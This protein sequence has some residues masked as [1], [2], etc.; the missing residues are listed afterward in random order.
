MNESEDFYK[1]GLRFHCTRCSM[2]CRFDTGYVFLSENDLHRIA[3]G[4]GQSIESVA[5]N[6]CR[7]VDLGVASRLS[8]REQPNKDCVFWVHG[9]CSIYEHRPLQ[10]RSFPFWP[11][12]LQNRADWDEVERE[13]PG[14]NIG[15]V[16]SAEEIRGWLLAH[17]RDSL[18]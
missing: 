4:L 14:V 9:G 1:N 3:K 16:H 7:R 5:E 17:K 8:L 13:C 2:C 6:Y 11:A 18:L 12:H 15:S 10:C